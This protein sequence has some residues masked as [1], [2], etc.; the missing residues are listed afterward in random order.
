MKYI[1]KTIF[2]L[3]IFKSKYRLNYIFLWTRRVCI[4]LSG[5]WIYL[6]YLSSETE[7][8]IEAKMLLKSNFCTSIVKWSSS[9]GKEMGSKPLL[10]TTRLSLANSTSKMVS[11]STERS[12]QGIREKRFSKN[13]IRIYWSLVTSSPR[14]LFYNRYFI[15]WYFTWTEHENL[16][17]PITASKLALTGCFSVSHTHL[18]LKRM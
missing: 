4:N 11:T 5:L 7:K 2:W 15:Y 9:E 12:L 14:D 17:K 13:F 8:D 1:F 3:Y 10:P 16:V 18:L 6:V